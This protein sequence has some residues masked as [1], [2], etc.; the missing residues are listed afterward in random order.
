MKL[1]EQI[2]FLLLEKNNIKGDNNKKIIIIMTIKPHCT[3][4]LKL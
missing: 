1:L 2:I 3:K 4:I